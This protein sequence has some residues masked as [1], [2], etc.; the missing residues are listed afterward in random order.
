MRQTIIAG[1]WKM[2][3]TRASAEALLGE[4]IP[5]IANAS[6]KVIV[7]PTSTALET[8]GDII[9]DTN[10]AL[11][12]QDLFWKAKGAYTGQISAGMLL[13]LGCEYVIVGHSECRGRFGVPEPDFTPTI[14]AYFGDS[15]TTVNLKLRAALA[16]NL[17]PILCVGETLQERQ[18]GNTDSVVAAQTKAGLAE[19]SAEDAVEVIFA[20]EPVWA[21]GTGEVCASDEADRVCGVVRSAVA[22][23]YGSEVA[24]AVHIQYG[25][26]VKPDNAIELLAKP[27]IDGALVGGASL[28]A[29]D[30]A[31]IVNAAP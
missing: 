10:I 7:C 9:A 16:N 29:Q 15:D 23:L 6:A 26:S 27:N 3:G 12:G 4:L 25:G 11:G 2:N 19:V 31:A 21:I 8:V 17:I 28:K 20:Y 13:D 1:N 14:L 30:F 5:L 24:E 18:A 22:E